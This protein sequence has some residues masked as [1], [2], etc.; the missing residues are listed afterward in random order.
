MTIKK[1]ISWS[2]KEFSRLPWR[3]H[4]SL[5]TTLVSEI[6]LQQTTVGTVKNHFDRFI[7]K[8]PDLKSLSQS[9]E[10]DLLI[11]WKGLGYYRRA[12]NLK[13]IADEIIKTYEGKF[14]KNRDDLQKIPG[15]GP[16]TSSALISIGMDLPG[17][18][19]DAN[20]E[21][22]ISRLF[23]LKIEKGPKL[24][25]EI[26]SLFE[27]K[28]IF[29]FKDLSYRELN[30]ALMD[31]GRTYCQSRKTS[32][33]LCPL[34]SECIAFQAKKPLSFP[35]E[36]SKKKS[37]E[38]E[39]H[40]LRCFVFKGSK[41]LVYKKNEDE[42]LSGQFEVPTFVI[43][44]SDPKLK[45]YPLLEKDLDRESLTVLKTGITKYK[46]Q[47]YLCPMNLKEFK[48]LKFEKEICWVNL[49][50]KELNLSVTTLKGLKKIGKH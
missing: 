1:L 13:K 14:P 34:S 35:F 10:E 46:I 2:K 32:C 26:L 21:R 48:L 22:V 47:N 7:A 39:L 37:T 45:Q 49:K 25:K 20:I 19:V 42:W 4:R 36:V 8:Y 44:S 31:L 3:Q 16:Y 24:Q 43:E 30:E 41:L 33:E 28:K 11:A 5:Y 6:M 23:G 29:N 15:I 17:L 38:H 9:S 18:A 40:L 12:K 27:K 50:G